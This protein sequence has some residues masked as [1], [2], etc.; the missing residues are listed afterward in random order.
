MRLTFLF[1]SYI[2]PY[3]F[4]HIALSLNGVGYLTE[5]SSTGGNVALAMTSGAFA[6]VSN[7]HHTQLQLGSRLRTPGPLTS[8]R[9]RRPRRSRSACGDY[10]PSINS[11]SS[12][13]TYKLIVLGK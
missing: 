10:A 2:L 1:F 3:A 13:I 8:A 7:L 4:L 12:G 11:V 5:D 6:T 9:A